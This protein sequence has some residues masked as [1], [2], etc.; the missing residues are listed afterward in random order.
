MTSLQ[1]CPLDFSPKK[2]SG[3]PRNLPERTCCYYTLPICCV[4]NS[5]VIFLGFIAARYTRLFLLSVPE[6]LG[7]N[8]LQESS[9]LQL[10]PVI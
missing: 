5:I 4:F 3:R 6:G 9:W 1:L 2:T 7:N 10:E 8:P